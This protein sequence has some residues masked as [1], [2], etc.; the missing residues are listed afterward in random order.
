MATKK[1]DAA[2]SPEDLGLP[3]E[4]IDDVMKSESGEDPEIQAEGPAPKRRGRPA[5][6]NAKKTG[7]T[8]RKT[9]S[10][11]SDDVAAMARQICGLHQMASMVTGLPELVISEQEGF[12]LAKG[13]DA[14]AEEYGLALSGK[15]GAAIQLFGAAAL[16]YLPR[17][18]LIKARAAKVKAD[19]V[20]RDETALDGSGLV[21]HV[22]SATH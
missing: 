21:H 8:P 11:K 15:T 5:G 16:V 14:M 22:N 9:A 1:D 2:P 19:E 17:M 18:L 20:K 10:R 7:E 4:A 3:L 13:V 6:S 12:M